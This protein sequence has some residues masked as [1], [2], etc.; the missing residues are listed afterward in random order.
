MQLHREGDK[1][2]YISRAAIDHGER[3]NYSLMDE[4]VKRQVREETCI[5]DGEL[6]VWNKLRWEL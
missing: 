5:L 4:A 1:I 6:I 2:Q 3:S